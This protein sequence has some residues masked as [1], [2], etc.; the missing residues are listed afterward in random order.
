MKKLRNWKMN[1]NETNFNASFF[2]FLVKCG[3]YAA[4]N[5]VLK[6][7]IQSNFYIDPRVFN[8]NGSINSV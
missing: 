8:Y 2:L 1:S 6:T 3:H 4:H 7:Q 5:N